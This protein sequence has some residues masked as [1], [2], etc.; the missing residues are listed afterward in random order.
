VSAIETQMPADEPD[1]F[2]PDAQVRRELGNV[3]LTTLRKWE[4]IPDLNFPPVIRIMERNY[5]SRRQLEEFKA[6]AIRRGATTKIEPRGDAIRR[7][8]LGKKKKRSRK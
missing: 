5:R 6:A 1:Q 4:R 8:E 3:T 2:V 7:A